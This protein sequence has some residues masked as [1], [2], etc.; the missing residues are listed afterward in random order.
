MDF[1]T[2][3][4]ARFSSRNYKDQPVEEE[5]LIKVLEAGR[6]AP[7]AANRQ[8]WIFYVFRQKENLEKIREVYHQQWFKTS[9]VVIL[10]CADHH[11]GW[12]RKDGKDHCDI[13]IAIAVT[14]ITL[15]ATELGLA[16]CWI[17]NFDA[18]KCREILQLPANIEP[19]VLL[20]LAY[21]ADSPDVNRHEKT[22]K[23]IQEI[24]KWM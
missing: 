7:S 17:C 8:P 3:E 2:L 21:P 16:T 11:S 5:K 4:R 1:N 13:D 12:T 22:R 15:Q 18:V 14:H 10:A 24:T 23:S 9:P 20:P 19:V 6:I